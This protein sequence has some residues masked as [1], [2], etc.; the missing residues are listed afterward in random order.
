MQLPFLPSGGGA[1]GQRRRLKARA[2]VQVSGA[3]LTPA[4]RLFVAAVSSSACPA[5]RTAGAVWSA[6]ENAQLI[7]PAQALCVDKIE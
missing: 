6:C 4:L 7:V 3:V 5:W 2:A 1:G